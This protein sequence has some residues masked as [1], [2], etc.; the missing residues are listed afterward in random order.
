M[1]QPRLQSGKY[2]ITRKQVLAFSGVSLEEA[3]FQLISQLRVAETGSNLSI[4]HMK[5]AG[6]TKSI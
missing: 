2:H 4:W 3:I 1:R 6:F 5:L